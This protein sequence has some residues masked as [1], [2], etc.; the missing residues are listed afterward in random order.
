[1]KNSWRWQAILLA[2]LLVT[3]LVACPTPIVDPPI[4]PPIDPPIDTG[5]ITGSDLLI[6]EVGSAYYADQ[7]SWFEVYNPTNSTINLSAYTLR[8]Q[9]IPTNN[10]SNAITTTWTLP[11]YDL[12]AGAYMVIGGKVSTNVFNTNKSVYVVNNNTVPYWLSN[13]FLELLKGGTSID[14]VRWGSNN[15][16][17]TDVAAWTGTNSPALPIGKDANN[18]PVDL[19]KSI[20]RAGAD[21]NSKSNW[22]SRNYATPAAPNDVPANAVD[23]DNDGIPDSAEVNGGKFGGLDLFAMGARTN[24]RDIFMELD[25]MTSSDPGLNPQKTALDI[26]VA[27]FAAKNI[28]LHVDAGDAFSA[29]F[30]PSNYNLGNAARLLPYSQSISLSPDAGRASSVYE[31]K[32][33]YFDFTRNLIFYYMVLGSSQNADGSSGSSGL[34]E[35]LGND[36]MVTFG[37]WGFNPNTTAKTNTLNNLMAST[38]MHEFGHNLGL[39]HGGNENR[40]YKPN[41]I[42]I[43]SYLYQLDC[44][45]PVVGTGV[46]DRYFYNYN[47]PQI[48]YSQL[49]NNP[50][51]TNCKLDFSDGSSTNLDENNLN[52][53]AGMGRGAAN[54]DWNV[55]G[56]IQTSISKN[57]N[58]NSDNTLN[59]L[60][61]YDDWSNIRFGFS[62]MESTYTNSASRQVKPS[63]VPVSNDRQE[64]YP[65]T[66]PSATFFNRLSS[67]MK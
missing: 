28:S 15:I 5:A 40:N 52:E 13:G 51:T 23:A 22:S 33:Q 50:T 39:R 38:I 27:A 7:I 30:D 11:S 62:R 47:P 67:E 55:S 4:E 17:P 8:G 60:T 37:G 6:S 14:F 57:L 44:L 16:A 29:G 61:D 3:G 2:A 31:L 18:R 1:M 19:G 46:A 58:P 32:S 54:I 45:G 49:V 53:T 42:S 12:A 10:S 21:N 56:T 66:P 63:L 59:V 65:E 64:I 35:I 24:Q 9:G 48:S 20:V 36:G 26:L 43:M 34:A 25:N 41:Y